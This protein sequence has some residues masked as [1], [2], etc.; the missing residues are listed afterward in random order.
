MLRHRRSITAA[1]GAFV[2][3][4]SL[5]ACGLISSSSTASMDPTTSAPS[6][7]SAMVPTP[8]AST[9]STTRGGLMEV[10]HTKLGLLLANPHG[11]TVYYY[12]ADK[13]GSGVSDC[14]GSCAVAWPPVAA[15]IRLP[16]GVTLAGTVGFIVRSNGEHQVT[17]NGY[18][19]YRYEGDMAPGQT[20]GN[21][22]GGKWWVIKV[23]ESGSSAKSGSSGMGSSGKGSSGS[24]SSGSGS[25][26]SGSGGSGSGGGGGW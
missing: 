24:G 19:I 2:A 15:P 16:A 7:G 18:P 23:K 1:A 5:S 22:V 8:T 14:T 20:N 9:M 26:G 12:T 25:S 6:A 4:I 3:V 13:K 11:M 10:K 17:V 21:G